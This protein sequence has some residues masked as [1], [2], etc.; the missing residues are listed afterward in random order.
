MNVSFDDLL[1]M[2]NV[3]II[4]IREKDKYS[5]SH[6]KGAINILEYDLLYNTNKYLNKREVYYIYCDYGNRSEDVTNKLQRRGYNV[7]NVIGGY[8][9]YLFS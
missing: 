7:I 3:N 8:N 1:N 5:Y 9:N 4:D 2:N 6:V